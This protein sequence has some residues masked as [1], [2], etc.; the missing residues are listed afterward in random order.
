MLGMW[1]CSA[2]IL[3]PP[4]RAAPSGRA[5]GSGND[6]EPKTQNKPK[7]MN[8]LIIRTKTDRKSALLAGRILGETA[9]I[10][11]SPDTIGDQW[12]RLVAMLDMNTEPPAADVT[13]DDPTAE[14]V[15]SALESIAVAEAAKQADDQAQLDQAVETAKRDLAA[16]DLA[17]KGSMKPV[18]MYASEDLSTF[19]G[20]GS[21]AFSGWE[22]RLPFLLI[23]TYGLPPSSPMREMAAAKAA[24]DERN[25]AEINAADQA[26]FE[27]AM[28]DL[29]RQRA[30][31]LE[32]Q[33]AAEAAKKAARAVKF[34][35]RLATGYWTRDTSSYN[36]KRHSAP[37]CAQVDFSVGSKGEYAFGESTGKWGKAGMMRVQCSPGEFI[38]YGQKDTRRPDKSEHTILRMRADGSMEDMG[39]KADAYKAYLEMQ[40]A[41]A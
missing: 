32:A 2:D 9:D 41:A 22:R 37:W 19:A 23:S 15:R 28:P 18:T 13:I 24:I 11:V 26:A 21:F 1:P 25:E 12:P 35:E 5:A 40:K 16:Y 39:S 33:A 14:A 7:Y 27:A 3:T 17:S 8:S 20:H 38:A 6:A 4:L 30:E 34:A 31:K 29:E 36:D 10:E